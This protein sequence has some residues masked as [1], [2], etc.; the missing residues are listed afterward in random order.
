MSD[1]GGCFQI[2][3]GV[4]GFVAKEWANK[5]RIQ[6]FAANSDGNC[7]GKGLKMEAR[8]WPQPQR[9]DIPKE[10]KELFGV[11]RDS[12]KAKGVHLP[13]PALLRSWVLLV[14]SETTSGLVMANRL[15]KFYMRDRERSEAELPGTVRGIKVLSSLTAVVPRPGRGAERDGRRLVFVL[16]LNC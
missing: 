7:P 10:R 4:T 13:S 12:S 5:S 3:A 9:M 6:A 15:S 2:S 16:G 14:Q 11:R 1:G 8:K